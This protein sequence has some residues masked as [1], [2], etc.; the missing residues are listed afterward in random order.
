VPFLGLLSPFFGQLNEHG[1]DRRIGC[2]SGFGRIAG[3]RQRLLEIRQTVG[4][5]DAKDNVAP[6]TEEIEELELERRGSLPRLVDVNQ[7]L[8]QLEAQIGFLSL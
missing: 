3:G 5:L 2:T 1:L 7:H 4:L 8:G 6:V